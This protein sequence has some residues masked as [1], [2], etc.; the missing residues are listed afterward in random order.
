M[1]IRIAALL[2]CAATSV[3]A[4]T[5]LPNAWVTQQMVA[6]RQA[7]RTPPAKSVAAEPA[8]TT[9]SAPGAALAAATAPA[10]ASAN[11]VLRQRATAAAPDLALRK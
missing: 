2:V 10:S 7:A 1:N 5:E 8:A 11:E 6:A 9:M 4:Q 3:Q